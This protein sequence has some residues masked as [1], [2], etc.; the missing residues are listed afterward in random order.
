MVEQFIGNRASLPAYPR[1]RNSCRHAQKPA[2]QMAELLMRANRLGSPQQRSRRLPLGLGEVCPCHP[3]KSQANS[4]EA[5]R[6]PYQVLSLK[7]RPQTFE[8]VLGQNHVIR[9]LQNALQSDHLVPAYLFIGPRGIGKTSIA[10][11]FAKALNC[12]K[13]PTSHPCGSCRSCQAIAAGTDFDVLEIDGASNN[14]I[15]QVREIRDKIRSS[16]LHSRFKI[17]LIDE[18]HMLTTPAFNSL[19][20]IIEE[21]PAHVKFLFATTEADQLPA[22]FTSLCQSFLLQPIAEDIIAQHLET[23]AKE[24]NVSLDPA[25][26][27]LL[28]HAAKGGMRDAESMLDQLISY[29]VGKI[30][31][32]SVSEVFAFIPPQE[33][34][35]LMEAIL[36][37]DLPNALRQVERLLDSGRNAETMLYDLAELSNNLLLAKVGHYE[38][39]AE[40]ENIPTRRLVDL[41]QTMAD[42]KAEMQG[43]TNKRIPLLTAVI[44]SMR[45]LHDADINEV[46]EALSQV[47]AEVKKQQKT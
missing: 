43:K 8:E 1:K 15:E 45:N 16:P 42:A 35:N 32:D 9:T 27:M 22:P 31:P 4:G 23:I 36:A 41:N 11:I 37:G 20:K 17:Y 10:R 5:N 21:P 12:E 34:E 33:T 14:G 38:C 18:V 39:P 25:A 30:T 40:L 3:S 47:Q 28:A 29:C 44:H 2:P 26:A 6:M 7:Y 24:E 13:G 19:Q 46:L